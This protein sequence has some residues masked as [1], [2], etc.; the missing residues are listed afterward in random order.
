MSDELDPELS[1]RIDFMADQVDSILRGHGVALVESDPEYAELIK[2]VKLG[3]QTG[4]H[5]AVLWAADR[6]GRSKAERVA[7]TQAAGSLDLLESARQKNVGPVPPPT[8]APPAQETTL[9]VL[10]RAHKSNG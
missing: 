6:A 5:G 9:E 1:A 2:A 4:D 3:A 7:A 8:P 10:E